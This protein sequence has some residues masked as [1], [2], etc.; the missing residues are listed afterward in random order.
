MIVKVP[1]RARAVLMKNSERARSVDSY[2]SRLRMT[3][4]QA[5]Q[6]KIVANAINSRIL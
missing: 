3:R 2:G 1:V 6:L 4:V 5:A